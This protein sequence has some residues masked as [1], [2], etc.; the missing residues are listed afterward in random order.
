MSNTNKNT[1]ISTISKDIEKQIYNTPYIRNVII[2]YY[3]SNHTS[4]C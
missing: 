1:Y 2:I 4:R 3:Y